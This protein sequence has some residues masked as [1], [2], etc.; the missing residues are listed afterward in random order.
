MTQIFVLLLGI[1]EDMVQ[2]CHAKFL[3][4]PCYT[5]ILRSGKN[6]KPMSSPAYLLITETIQKTYHGFFLYCETIWPDTVAAPHKYLTVND[7]TVTDINYA[8]NQ[9]LMIEIKAIIYVSNITSS[10]MKMFGIT[11][12]KCIN[13]SNTKMSLFIQ[14]TQ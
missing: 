14:C 8:L 5:S 3:C 11:I 10:P 1:P 9:T 13:T 7:L 4:P 2:L 6:L 12:F